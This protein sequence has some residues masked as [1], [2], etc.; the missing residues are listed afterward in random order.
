MQARHVRALLASGILAGFIAAPSGLEAQSGGWRDRQDAQGRQM[1]FRNMDSDG[2]GVIT[3]AEWRG[4]LQA[5]QQQD[6]NGDNV[7]SGPEVWTA[8]RG[9]GNKPGDMSNVFERAD[10]NN[11][12]LLSRDEW[13]GDLQT[14]ERI[15][16]ND[17][18]RISLA[19][20]LGEESAGSSGQR[21]SFAALDRN[22]NGVLTVSEWT[23][24]RAAFDAL[25]ADNDGV[26]TRA[27][28]SR[29]ENRTPAYRAG[30]TRGLAEGR[31]AGQQDRRAGRPWDLDG[32]RELV[33][34]DSGYNSSLGPRNEYQ[35]GYREGFR[36]GY[37][38]GF[39]RK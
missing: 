26:I 1:R 3:R 25:D 30:Y 19:E 7:L 16:R 37:A 2:D 14:F 39:G 35:D 33:Q 24:D 36:R 22:R 23:G 4:S 27:E 38:V 8:G 10:R 18:G 17:D 31:Q 11:D 20:F 5:F 12:G 6:T 15:D 29:D 32:Q 13:Y 21:E 34:A 28:F 9:T